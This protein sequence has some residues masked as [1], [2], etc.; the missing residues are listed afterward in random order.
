MKLFNGANIVLSEIPVLG[1]QLFR[2][3]IISQCQEGARLVNFFGHEEV[4]GGV[5]LFA[6]L[7]WDEDSEITVF[8]TRILADHP[9]YESLT[10][11]LIQAHWFEREVAEQWAIIPEGHPWLKPLRYHANYRGKAD[12]WPDVSSRPIPGSYSFYA[13]ESPEVHEVGVGPVHAGIIEPGHFRFQC[14][15]EEVM[16]LEIQ[17]GYQH[18]G[19]ELLMRGRDFKRSALLSEAIAGDTAVGHSIAHCEVV[20]SLSGCVIP[21]KAQAIRAVALELERLS[22]HVGD[23]GAMSADVGFLPT[24]AYFGRMRG[25]YLNLLLALTGNRFGKGL[26]RPGGVLF[27][28]DSQ[29]AEEFCRK[30]KGYKKEFEDVSNLLF[31]K[32]SV[33]A[34]FEGVGAISMENA[35]KIGLVGPAGRACRLERDVRIDYSSGFWQFSHIPISLAATGDVFG[36]ALVRRQEV[37]R[38]LEFLLRILSSLPQGGIFVKPPAL[39]P[40]SLALS[41]VEGWRG[42]IMH[43]GITDENG[44]FARYKIKD[45]SFHNWFGLSLA[46]RGQEISDFPLCNK[47]FNLSYCGHDL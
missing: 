41:L 24:S 37:V 6:F 7:G 15:G 11:D 44:G 36:R 33:L 30:L 4:D 17:L 1:V 20:E 12:I 13:V 26:C 40:D 29:M 43:V 2:E 46:M 10:K 19:L 39:K 47:S 35:K 38:S 3:K 34:R 42:E 21:P 23:L 22:N 31:T 32:P 27:D 5:R 14:H 28:V 8:S 9:Q 18:R 16:H 45:P 25:D